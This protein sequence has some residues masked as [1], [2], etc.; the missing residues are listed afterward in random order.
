MRT[1]S[2]PSRAAPKL[3]GLAISPSTIST[4]GTLL[5]PVAFALFLTKIR[6]GTRSRT[7]SFAMKEPAETGRSCEKDHRILPVGFTLQRERASEARRP[8]EPTTFGIAEKSHRRHYL[9]RNRSMG[10]C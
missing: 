8:H 5:N 3:S 4:V 9:P 1:R 6:R 10:T 7:N 2:T